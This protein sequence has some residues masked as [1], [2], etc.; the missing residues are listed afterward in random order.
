M[1]D[2]YP[3]F[4]YVYLYSHT[5]K[6][7]PISKRVPKYINFLFTHHNN[8]R[9]SIIVNIVQ[10]WYGSSPLCKLHTYYNMFSIIY[11]LNVS[12]QRSSSALTN[13]SPAGTLL[14]LF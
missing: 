3:C 4:F 14:G 5:L 9:V 11:Y 10:L 13:K 1:F 8:P 12:R 6:V 2:I 7:L